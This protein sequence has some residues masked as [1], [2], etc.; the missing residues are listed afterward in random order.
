LSQSRFALG[1][2][3]FVKMLKL[4]AAE[5]IASNLA[6]SSSQGISTNASCRMSKVGS[7]ASVTRVTMPN[8]PR[9]R[10]ISA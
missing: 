4:Y 9:P 8:A 6:S 5:E 7:I 1:P 3:H 2:D 10:S